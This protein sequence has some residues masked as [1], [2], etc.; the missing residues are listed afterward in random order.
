MNFSETARLKVFTCS[1][2]KG[3]AAAITN[4]G[5]K[6]MSLN[7][8]DRNGAMGDVVLGYDTPEQYISG[9]P[10]FGA[11]IGRF[12]NRIA[13]G[14][15]SIDNINYQLNLN[16]GRN[17]LHG[18]PNGFHNKIWN[19]NQKDLHSLELTLMSPDGEEGYPGDLNVSVNYTMTEENELVIEYF[20]TTT[21]TT[22][23]NLTNHAFFNLAGKGD[24][25][26]HE[27]KIMADY[28][29]PI[30]EGLIPTGEFLPVQETPF[31]FREVHP[32]G[33]RIVNEAI[34]LQYANGY[35]H[36]YVLN[37]EAGAFSLAASVRDPV[38]GRV[39]E[40]W[41]TEPGL[42]FYTGNFLDGSDIGK[43]GQPYAIRSALCLEAQHFPDSPN[44]QSFPTTL[45]HPGEIYQQK[46]TYKFGVD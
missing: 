30:N 8:P 10:Y 33:E 46:T 7:V 12:G 18:G 39:L 24:I 9:N 32:I 1:N 31:D 35:D 26:K 3:L 20:A 36:S 14:R 37:K 17:S 45:L 2:S 43:Q 6:I 21:K 27:L 16:N 13:E 38:S 15:F 41:T 40:V 23:I 25:L 4:L 11:L 28:F 5:G 42:Q 34:Q 19:C 44:H 22:I 29:I